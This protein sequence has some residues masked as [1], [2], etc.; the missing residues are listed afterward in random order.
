MGHEARGRFRVWL[1]VGTDVL[2][3][4]LLRPSGVGQAFRTLCRGALFASSGRVMKNTPFFGWWDFSESLGS[5]GVFYIFHQLFGSLF[6]ANGTGIHP[7]L[8]VT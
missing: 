2:N 8:C 3:G 6:S 7:N 1:V 4:P 5:H